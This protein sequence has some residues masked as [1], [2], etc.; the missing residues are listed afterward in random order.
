MRQVRLKHSMQLL[1]TS[2]LSISEIGYLVGFSTPAYFSTRFAEHYGYA[3]SE[4]RSQPKV[5]VNK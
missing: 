1:Q 2:D 4:V 3:P 5:L